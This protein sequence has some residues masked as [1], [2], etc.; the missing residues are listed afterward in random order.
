MGADTGMALSG[1]DGR[2]GGVV[3]RSPADKHLQSLLQITAREKYAM[4][5]ALAPQSNVGPKPDDRPLERSTGMRLA[6]PND[7]PDENIEWPSDHR[8][9]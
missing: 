8:P 2:Q 3:A 5:T 7:V 9:S 4:L 6:Q 1:L